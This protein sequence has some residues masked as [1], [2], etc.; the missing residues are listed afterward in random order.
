[1]WPTRTSQVES[2][3]DPAVIAEHLASLPKP[4]PV[5]GVGGL[6][7]AVA[8]AKPGPPAKKDDPAQGTLDLAKPADVDE[9]SPIER[10]RV[11]G[12]CEHCATWIEVGTGRKTIFGQRGV[13]VC[14]P[15][16]RP[17]S[18]V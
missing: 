6:A 15:A 5:P 12:R 8:S 2:A 18:V 9:N 16:C 4:K 3:I 7:A 1:M 14:N 11:A 10:N 13:I 17:A